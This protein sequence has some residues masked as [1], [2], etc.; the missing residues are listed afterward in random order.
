MGRVWSIANDSDIT[1]FRDVTKAGLPETGWASRLENLSYPYVDL[2]LGIGPIWI[3]NF[4]Q[5]DYSVC[6]V[7]LLTRRR[8]ICLNG[9]GSKFSK[10]VADHISRMCTAYNMF[11]C[12]MQNFGIIFRF[13]HFIWILGRAVMP[14]GR[15]IIYWTGICMC[16]FAL[17]NFAEKLAKFK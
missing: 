3:L 14:L 5:L 13:V 4:R 1:N 15:M 12:F 16:D 11:E 7:I 10:T 2:S 17:Q 6:L 9:S 8:F